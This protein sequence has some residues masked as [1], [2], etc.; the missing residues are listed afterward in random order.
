MVTFIEVVVVALLTYYI[1]KTEDSLEDEPV[2]VGPLGDTFRNPRECPVCKQEFNGEDRRPRNLQCSHHL[3]TS[4]IDTMLRNGA[5]FCP[6][7]REYVSGVS[8]KHFKINYGVEDFMRFQDSADRG[9]GSH[10]MSKRMARMTKEY[11]D[12]TEKLVNDCEDRE[13]QLKDR[14]NTITPLEED[15]N[16]AIETVECELRAKLQ[17][18]VHL[19]KMAIQELGRES[20]RIRSQIL[21]SENK[22]KELQVVSEELEQAKTSGDAAN[23]LGMA[24]VC[25]HEIE[26]WMV[27]HDLPPENKDALKKAEKVCKSTKDK[28][29]LILE[30]INS[31]EINGN[32][33]F[34]SSTFCRKLNLPEVITGD[35]VLQM[36]EDIRLLAEQELLFAVQ[37][38]RGQVSC[39][40]ISYR[41]NHLYL[42]CLLNKLPPQN[43]RTIGYKELMSL[44]EKSM[45]SFLEIG[46]KEKVL[47]RVHI[48]L[49]PDNPRAKNFALLCSGM[50]EV[51]YIN[52]KLLETWGKGQNRE[53][54][55]GGDYARN[56]GEGGAPLVP[57]P[58]ENEKKSDP[59]R[60]GSVWGKRAETSAS[61]FYISTRD[62]PGEMIK[63]L[64]GR[65]ED[66]LQVVKDA[67]QSFDDIRQLKIT[68]CGFVFHPSSHSES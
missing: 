28:V 2:F 16:A 4:C 63:G 26:E 43:A 13:G 11:I 17:V 18:L 21:E 47:G 23:S 57:V 25:H 53:H 54:I 32:L 30:I 33:V 42:H 55:R 51:S 65:V 49:L 50:K 36:G 59:W 34:R 44:K 5:S 66:G 3:C 22:R 14:L 29:N 48:R 52:S 10:P 41:G 60:A 68:D 67:I 6:I 31:E 7:C 35:I 64:F 37:R 38:G 27:N 8:A 46:S 56:T 20:N 40:K 39:A 58:M 45:L 62:D 61:Q 24:D 9:K 15:L 19:N 1:L 12:A